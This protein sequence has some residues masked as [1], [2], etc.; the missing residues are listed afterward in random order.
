MMDDNKR[1]IIKMAETITEQ[2]RD[3][4][5]YKSRL[6]ETE[7]TILDLRKKIEENLFIE[8][9]VKEVF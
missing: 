9:S 6:R 5:Y 3:I 7:E 4:E 1:T 2:Q 8:K